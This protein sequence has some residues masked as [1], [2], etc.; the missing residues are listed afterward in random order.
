M[1][2]YNPSL[3][4]AIFSSVKNE[5]YQAEL[6]VLCRI[7]S[8]SP[9]RVRIVAA[10][11]ENALSLPTQDIAAEVNAVGVNPARFSC[12]V[13]NTV[14]AYLPTLADFAAPDVCRLNEF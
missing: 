6:P 13:A 7:H 14:H 11:G 5:D 10:S 1:T 3:R 4:S 9:L 2:L 8:G 12:A